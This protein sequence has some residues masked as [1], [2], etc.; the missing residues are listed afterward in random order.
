MAIAPA[1]ARKI[2]AG[3]DASMAKWFDIE[4][5]PKDMAFDHNEMAKFAIGKLK[6]KKIYKLNCKT[7]A[8]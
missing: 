8:K 3:D 1:A 4:S 6:R 2:K 5:L 7:A